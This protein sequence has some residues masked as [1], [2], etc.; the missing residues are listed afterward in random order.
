MCQVVS[1]RIPYA[2]EMSSLSAFDPTDKCVV[3]ARNCKFDN[4][5]KYNMQCVPCNSELLA[6][7]TLFLT[8]KSTF[9]PKSSKKCVNYYKIAYARA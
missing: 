1:I 7:K 9:G 4:L 2:L 3:F 5:I 6:Q 8:K